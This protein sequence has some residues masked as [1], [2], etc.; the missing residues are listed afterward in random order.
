M[1]QRAN[2]AYILTYF[3]DGIELFWKDVHEFL[4]KHPNVRYIGSQLERTPTTG[5]FHWQAFVKL[6]NKE[7]IAW[8]KKTIDPVIHCEA[9]TIERAEA[10]QYG[11]KEDTRVE[12]P[13]ESGEKPKAVDRHSLGGQR[14]KAEWD[15]VKQCVLEGRKCDI[16]TDI[17]FK[18]GVEKRFEALR[19]FWTVDDRVN[20]PSSLPNPW[21]LTI[22]V[23]SKETKCRHIWL[24]SREPNEGKTT[25]L[26]RWRKDYKVYIKAGDFTYWDI[27]GNEDCVALDDYNEPSLKYHHLN[28][29]CDGTYGYRVI[30]KGNIVLDNPL[31][32][33]SSN[34]S[35]KDLYPDRA[36][37]LY[38]RFNEYE[39]QLP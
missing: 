11:I 39:V 21:E 23:E 8:F 19:R 20:L 38:A 28:Q 32:I 30:Y 10:I 12:G 14:T 9:V 31:I 6:V 1:N 5:R 4:G 16:P 18:Y 27:E 25:T 26:R 17:M 24:Y 36:V 2:I 35:I 7:R 22:R 13:L 15:L 34:F 37:F 29:M 33:V 3:C